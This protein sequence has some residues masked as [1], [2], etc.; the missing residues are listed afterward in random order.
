MRTPIRQGW[1]DASKEIADADDDGLIWP[2]FGNDADPELLWVGFGQLEN[3]PP[4]HE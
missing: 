2:E 1:A 3:Q 4:C